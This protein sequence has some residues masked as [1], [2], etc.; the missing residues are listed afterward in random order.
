MKVWIDGDNLVRR[1]QIIGPLLE[2]EPDAIV[3]QLDLSGQ[4]AGRYRRAR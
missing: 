2:G 3:H 4:R 1:L